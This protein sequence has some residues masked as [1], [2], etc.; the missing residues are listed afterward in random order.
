MSTIVVLHAQLT[1]F[2]ASLVNALLNRT[3][4]G[5]FKSSD[6]IAIR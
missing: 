6:A 2:N 1:A 4:D 5:C 3:A